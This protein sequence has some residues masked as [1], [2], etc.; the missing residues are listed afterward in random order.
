[1]FWWTSR[2]FSQSRSLRYEGAFRLVVHYILAGIRAG[3]YGAMDISSI[4][5]LRTK[6]SES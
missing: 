6:L 3:D 2:A 4:R 1:M 5:S